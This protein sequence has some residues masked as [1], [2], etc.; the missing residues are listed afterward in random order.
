MQ[1]R[2]PLRAAVAG[3]RTRRLLGC[4]TTDSCFRPVRPRLLRE[5]SQVL[6]RNLT[7]PR[8]ARLQTR[9]PLL[10]GGPQ[11]TRLDTPNLPGPHRLAATLHNPPS[12]LQEARCASFVAQSSRVQIDAYDLYQN[13]PLCH[14]MK[15]SLACPSL[16]LSFS[17]SK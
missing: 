6:G 17:A 5:D 15:L 8:D 10:L 7:P 4:R 12:L 1:E 16:C 9:L 2:G 13:K 14:A 3:L 11:H